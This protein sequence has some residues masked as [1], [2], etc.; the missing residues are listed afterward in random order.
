MNQQDNY[1]FL[2]V[3]ASSAFGSVP[4]PGA[5]VSVRTVNGDETTLYTVMTTNE[6][7]ETEAV[8]IPAPPADISLE[9]GNATPYS[10]VN[11]EIFAD[12]FYSVGIQNMP[13]FSG[14]T[15]TQSVNMIPLPESYK[16]SKY[17][18]ANIIISES[19]VPNL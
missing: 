3:R 1:G 17:P 2:L 13:I 16:Y 12:G 18:G 7:G 8:R 14:I 15:S 11:L 6:D 4:I 10:L 5:T 9:P 19:E